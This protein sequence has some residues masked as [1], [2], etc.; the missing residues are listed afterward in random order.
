MLPSPLPQARC[1][2]ETLPEARCHSQHVSKLLVTG[3]S[4]SLEPYT[5][6]VTV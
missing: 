1:W 3:R 5:Q 6:F 4:D 2:V